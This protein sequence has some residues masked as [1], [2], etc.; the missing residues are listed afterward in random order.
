[1]QLKLI[2]VQRVF[3][4]VWDVY[5]LYIPMHFVVRLSLSLGRKLGVCAIFITGLVMLPCFMTIIPRYQNK[6]PVFAQ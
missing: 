1:M 4:T 3:G 2:S 6:V 5:D